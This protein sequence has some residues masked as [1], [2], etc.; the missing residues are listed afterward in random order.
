MMKRIIFFLLALTL[1]SCSKNDLSIICVG[2]LDQSFLENNAIR[3]V[4][5]PNLTYLYRFEDDKVFKNHYDYGFPCSENSADYIRC[6]IDLT[7]G[8]G[9]VTTISL[10]KQSLFVT[11]HI[12]RKVPKNPNLPTSED[13]SG[14]CEKTE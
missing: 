1:V 12:L 6:V 3:H 4:S 11:D 7:L 10:N 5:T 13:F 8:D 14:R 9:S 2:S